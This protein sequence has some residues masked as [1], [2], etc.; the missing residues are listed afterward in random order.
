MDLCE[1]ESALEMQKCRKT[2]VNDCTIF[3]FAVQYFYLVSQNLIFS[4]FKFSTQFVSTLLVAFIA[5]FKVCLLFRKFASMLSEVSLQAL[6]QADT[7]RRDYSRGVIPAS[8]FSSHS[9][10]LIILIIYKFT[11]APFNI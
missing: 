4:D 10:N 7:C 3:L 5:V 6:K 8:A 1:L 2:F 9:R 11:L